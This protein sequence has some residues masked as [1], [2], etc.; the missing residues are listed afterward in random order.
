[1]ALR[2]AYFNTFNAQKMRML[3]FSRCSDD[4]RGSA[5]PEIDAAAVQSRKLKLAGAGGIFII[6]EVDRRQPIAL[7]NGTDVDGDE[8]PQT[9]GRSGSP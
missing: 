3:P 1:M 4:R 6:A 2:F 8:M 7:Y 5:W 9:T